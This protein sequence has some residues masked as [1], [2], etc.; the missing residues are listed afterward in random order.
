MCAARTERLCGAE[1]SGRSRSQAFGRQSVCMNKMATASDAKNSSLTEKRDAKSGDSLPVANLKIHTANPQPGATFQ[2]DQ[3]WW[4]RRVRTRQAWCSTPGAKANAVK[5]TVRRISSTENRI[6]HESLG[7]GTEYRNRADIGRERASRRR[8]S[9]DKHLHAAR[10]NNATLVSIVVADIWS[11][12]SA[13]L[14][15]TTRT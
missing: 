1:H 15:W 10:L 12:R 3:I 14:S 11:M 13:F 7:Y 8:I 4:R 9:G 2:S 5:P 6:A